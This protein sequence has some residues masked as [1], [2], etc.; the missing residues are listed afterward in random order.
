MI[1]LVKNEVK[2]IYEFRKL[3]RNPN[4]ACVNYDCSFA[5]N[6]DWYLGRCLYPNVLRKNASISLFALQYFEEYLLYGNYNMRL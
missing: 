3:D 2:K 6:M 1:K 5:I 4:I